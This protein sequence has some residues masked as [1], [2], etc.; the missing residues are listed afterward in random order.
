MVYNV[1]RTI[2]LTVCIISSDNDSVKSD[3]VKRVVSTTNEILSISAVLGWS[4]WISQNLC[5]LK[6]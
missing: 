4:Q 1:M 6:K 5:Y 3:S 2:D